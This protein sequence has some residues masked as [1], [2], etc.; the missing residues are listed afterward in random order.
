MPAA[1]ERPLPPCKPGELPADLGQPAYHPNKSTFLRNSIWLVVCLLLL[2]LAFL[3]DGPI[4]KLLTLGPAALPREIALCASKAGEGWVV[5]VAGALA[6]AILFL[7]RRFEASRVAFLLAF[8]G[9]ITGAAATIV[10]SL[11]GR[12]RPSAHELQGFYGIWHDSHWIIGKYEFGAFP[13]GHTATVVGLAAAAWLVNRRLGILAAF[14]A[15]FVSWSR[16]AL[17]CHHFS[18]VLAAAL[19]GIFGA[20]LILSRVGPTIHTF[21]QTLQNA[22]MRSGTSARPK[23][24]Q[25]SRA[26][27]PISE[28]PKDR[29]RRTAA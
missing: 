3:A 8:V 20:H 18:D 11:L 25:P 4:E 13:S 7:R 16:I 27:P 21:G 5:G 10:R 15:V 14:Y 28:L 29:S 2:A 23:P 19:L 24:D 6:C 1:F 17:G 9:L 22:W 26:H 12:T